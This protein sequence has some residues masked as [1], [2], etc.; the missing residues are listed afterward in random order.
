MHDVA[1]A[2]AHHAAM[3]GCKVK[4]SS[5]WRSILVLGL[6]AGLLSGCFLDPKVRKQHYFESGQ[7]YFAKGEFEEAAIQFTN[8]VKIDPGWADA[9]FQLG[10]SYMRLQR[11]DRA[12]Q[13][14]SRT[15]ELRPQD[16]KARIEL[17]NLLILVHRFP[18]AKEQTDLLVKQR[19]RDPAVHSTISILLAA[20]GDL[21]GAIGEMQQTIALD[22]GRWEFYLGLA[23][24]QQRNNQ[25]DLAEASF[26]KVVELNPKDMQQRVVLGNFY[27][28][29]KRPGEAEQQY[30]AAIAL[31]PKSLQPRE[32]LARLLL[33]TERKAEAEEVLKQ[34]KRDLPHEPGSYI[35]LSNFY[36]ATGDLEKAV[37]E[38]DALYKERPKD[39]PIK[40]RYIQLLILVKRIDEARKLNDEILNNDSSDDD[41]LVYRSQMQIGWGDVERAVDTLQT[42]VK[43]NPKSSLAHYAL[44]VAYDKQAHHLEHAESEWREAARLNPNLVEAQRALASAAM[45]LGDM[46]TLQDAAAQVIRLQP[47]SPD[48]YA[49]RSLAYINRQHYA[50]AEAD[51]RTVIAMAPQNAVGYIHLGHLR[52]AQRQFGDAAKAYQDALDRN[53]DATDALAGLMRA[54]IAQKEIDKAIAAAKTQIAKSPNNSRFYDLLGSV[55]FLDKKDLGEVQAAFEKSI[56]LDKQN[57][58]ARIHLVQAHAAKGEIDQAIATGEQSLK[59]NPQQTNLYI[60]MGNL[61]QS[62]RDS[63]KAEDAYQHALAI[64]SQNPLAANDLARL[65]LNTGENLDIALG[66]AQTAGKGLPNSAAVADTLG[67]IYYRKGVYPMAVSYLQQALQLQEKNKLRESPDIDYHLGW[68]YEK[69]QQPALARQHFEQVL[70]TSPNYPAAAEIK[71]EL[72][73]LKS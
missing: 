43:N 59:D 26:Q 52:M 22:P 41:A 56:A 64:N 4:L 24:L 73:H 11:P 19:P 31:D 21:P 49:L 5:N 67:W 72:A 8:A 61:Y 65:M 7:R 69:T 38:Y 27:M 46:T 9:H 14:L 70:K 33:V 16:Y 28:L 2:I 35:A 17:A 6:V 15:I 60:L 40:K 12:F 39:L 54:Y 58:D 20:Q 63:K 32:A 44:G 51:I 57:Y 10:E 13:E 47:G 50:E 30:R 68:A 29:Q 36:Y 1:A 71:K 3:R 42:V 45:R 25:P 48:G 34:A 18:Q 37:A 53:P 55:L 23:L 62:K 66:L